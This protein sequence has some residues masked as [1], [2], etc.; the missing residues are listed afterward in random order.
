VESKAV[1]YL[2]D[3]RVM[4]EIPDESIGL[5][6]TSPP[7]WHIKDYGAKEQI[8]Y[9]Q[10]LHEYLYELSR[11]WNECYRVLM[12]G[13]R[14]CI[15]IGDQFTRSKTYGRY[16][17]VPIHAEII[18]Q[19]EQIGFDYM[20][21]IIWQKKTT[22]RPSGGAVVMGSYP[23]PPNGI[24]ESDFEYILIFKKPGNL[25]APDTATKEASKLT[26]EEW[27][28]YFSGHWTFAGAKQIGHEAMFPEELPYRL[29]KMFSLVGDTVLDPFV[30]SG[31]TIKVALSLNRKAIGYDIQEE[32]INLWKARLSI[33]NNS[34]FTPDVRIERRTAQVQ[35]AP[36]PSNYKPQVQDM[37]AMFHE[38]ADNVSHETYYK[39]L[40]IVSHDALEIEQ[41]GIIRLAG[42]H[43]SEENA[44]KAIEYFKQYVLGKRVLVKIDPSLGQHEAYVY[45]SN[46]L[47]INRKIIEIGLA[48]AVKDIEYKYRDKFIKAEKNK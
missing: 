38:T 18:A 11:V 42:I 33:D 30:G 16:K 36:V 6:V 24:I 25:K 4:P 21:S 5:I 39:V 45:M 10:S 15:N 3:S 34:I 1:I 44:Q 32:Y 48:K 31:T 43:V 22:M 29:I 9:G 17:V 27:K 14:L 13:R 8:G 26:K 46:G 37:K 35:F 23:Y 19:C 41:H 2:A 28:T 12:P 40:R 7:Y 20:G 47:F